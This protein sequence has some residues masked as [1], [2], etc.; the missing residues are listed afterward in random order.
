LKAVNEGEGGRSAPRRSLGSYEK[1]S[2][3]DVWRERGEEAGKGSGMRSGMRKEA[4]ESEKGD[5][6]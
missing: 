2:H 5:L 3:R 1:D 6:L 4:E